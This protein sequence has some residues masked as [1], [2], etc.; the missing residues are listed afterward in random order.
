MRMRKTGGSQED[1][2]QLFKSSVSGNDKLLINQCDS[3]ALKIQQIGG[4]P[5]LFEGIG[6][7]TLTDSKVVG[8]FFKVLFHRLL[9]ISRDFKAARSLQKAWRARK[10]RS[11]LVGL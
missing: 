9:L 10:Q 11:Q 1:Y 7:T 8:F 2:L 5:I 6:D 4:V 3:F